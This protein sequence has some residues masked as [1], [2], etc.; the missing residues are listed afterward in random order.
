MKQTKDNTWELDLKTGKVELAQFKSGSIF[1]SASLDSS[2]TTE[3]WILT[4]RE[5]CRYFL[6]LNEKNA[7]RKGLNLLH[8]IRQTENLNFITP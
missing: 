3:T 1:I 6:A 8:K 4:Q 7:K 5:N 2:T